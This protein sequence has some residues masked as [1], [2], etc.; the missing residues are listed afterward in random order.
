[1]DIVYLRYVPSEKKFKIKYENPIIKQ[2][3]F[4]KK[5]TECI[6]NCMDRTTRNVEIF[7]S[8][9]SKINGQPILKPTMV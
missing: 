4:D 6:Q 3:I 9:K 1:M 2:F 5:D 8:K 7:L